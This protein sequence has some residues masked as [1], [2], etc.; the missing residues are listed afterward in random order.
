[1]Y[2]VSVY[3]IMCLVYCMLKCVLW[4]FMFVLHCVVL[5]T[6]H[7]ECIVLC[8]ECVHC[9]HLVYNV[10]CVILYCIVC[11]S[12]VGGWECCDGV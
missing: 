11:V 9:T 7:Y 3:I 12:V 10:W 2:I 1:M 4:G 5:L 8:I 6:V